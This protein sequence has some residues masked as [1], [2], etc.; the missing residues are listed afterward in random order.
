MILEAER[1]TLN[2]SQY[3]GFP[4]HV[5]LDNFLKRSQGPRS[6]QLYYVSS[7]VRKLLLG[8]SADAIKF[9]NTGVNAFSR[10]D[11]SSFACQFRLQAEVMDLVACGFIGKERIIEI[12][13]DDLLV[14]LLNEYP[15]LKFFYTETQAKLRAAG[16]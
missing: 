12:T 3:Y 9:I 4:E 14:A 8:P 1:E 7:T 15:R 10:T 6:K 13:L 5:P 11:N 16:K 2:I